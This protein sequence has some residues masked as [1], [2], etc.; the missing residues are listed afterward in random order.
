MQIKICGTPILRQTIDLPASKSISNRALILSALSGGTPQ[1]THISDCDDTFVMQRALQHPTPEID[2]KAAGTAMRFLTAYTAVGHDTHTL[3]GTARMKQRPIAILV[4]ALRELG[5]Q[6]GYAGQEGF[7]P[8]H[9]VG[10]QLHGGHLTLPGHVSSQYIS[11]LLM[12]GPMLAQGLSLTL[13]GHIISRPYIDLTIGMM[14]EFGAEVVWTSGQDIRVEATPYRPTPFYIEGDWSAASYWYQMVALSHDS[15]ARIC[16]PG[17]FA[18]SLQGDAAVAHMF[19]QLGVD[20]SH[21]HQADGTPMV[22]LT[23]NASCVSRLDYDFIDQPDLAQTLAVTCAMLQVPFHFRGLQS[24]RIKETDRIA[25]LMNELGK[26]GYVLHTQNDSELWWD[27]TRTAPQPHAAI[28]T[29]EDHRMA[30]AF[31]PCCLRLDNRHINNP[32]VVSK[33]YP[34][35]W[36]HLQAAG[37]NIQAL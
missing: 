16:L 32:E 6:I 28:D 24:L 8:L 5:A 30:M 36:D 33:S 12:I 10:T 15:E 19:A 9:I 17:L 20:T 13:T 1:P 34:S 25:A 26:L 22:T 2:I 4:D 27:G 21:G 14:R 18:T 35:Y 29:Y 23:K 3:T 7:P 37:F 31:A 11:A